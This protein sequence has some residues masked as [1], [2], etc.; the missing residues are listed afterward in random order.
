MSVD[1]GLQYMGGARYSGAR[2]HSLAHQWATIATYEPQNV[3]EIGAGSG[4]TAVVLK[5]LGVDVT[6]CD[7]DSSLDPDIV[8]DVRRLPFDDETYDVVSCCQ[9]LEHVPFDDFSRAIAEIVRVSRRAC[10]VSVPDNT[11]FASLSCHLPRIG[12]RTIAVALPRLR[13]RH[14]PDGRE[15]K[16][17]HLWEVGYDGISVRTVVRA[18]TSHGAVLSRTW[19]VPELPW[20]RFFLLAGKTH[21]GVSS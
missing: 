11:R 16:H 10:V 13:A 2:F 8:A 17:G 12:R 4:L 20:H 19:R 14:L 3:L 15:Q 21:G 6:V 18:M 9:V 1:Y 5:Q 7:I